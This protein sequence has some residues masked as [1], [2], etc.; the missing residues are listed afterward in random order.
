MSQDL[1]EE[2]LSQGPAQ[3]K[4]IATAGVAGGVAGGVPAKSR[5]MRVPKA[6]EASR[7]GAKVKRFARNWVQYEAVA[8]TFENHLREEVR[9]TL[10]D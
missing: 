3:S 8:G 1:P 9:S 7:A 6:P 2:R 10:C 5:M 4:R